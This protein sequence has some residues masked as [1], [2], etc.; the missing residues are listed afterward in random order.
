MQTEIK[1]CSVNE[2]IE[3]IDKLQWRHGNI[4]GGKS[5][6]FRGTSN[7]NWT[8][9]PKIFR[10]LP[11]PLHAVTMQGYIPAGDSI[12]YI[13][14]TEILAH[15]KKEASAI[16]PN[17]FQQEEFV[18]MQYAQHYG[19]PTRLLDFTTNPLVALYFACKDESLQDGCISIVNDRNFRRWS[20]QEDFV[21][22]SSEKHTIDSLISAILKEM[23]QRQ[24][25]QQS[26]SSPA[27]TKIRPVMIVLAYLDQRMLAQSSRFLLWGS[28]E[29]SLE[30]M[31]E[32]ENYMNPFSEERVDRSPDTRFFFQLIVDSISKHKLLQQLDMLG[33]NEKTLFP[34]LDGLGSYINTYY[35]R[36]PE[37]ELRF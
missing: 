21:K 30:E 16:V 10:K 31:L 35:K 34:G 27:N 20:Y 25:R 8:L 14:E 12:H 26:E 5:F 13:E 36:H 22:K 9:L 32:D 15:F 37:D 11:E 19:I 29:N 7:K 23:F 2:F 4:V 1:T 3:I 6:V 33:I 17:F 24:M 18:C 28:D